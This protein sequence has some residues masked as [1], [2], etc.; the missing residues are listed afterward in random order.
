MKI[1]DSKSEIYTVGIEEESHRIARSFNC[2][3]G[4]FPLTYLGLPISDRRLSKAELSGTATK[5]EKRLQAWK[6][7]HLSHGGR[8]ILINSSLTSIPMYTMGFYWLYEGNHQRVDFGRG[9]FFW[10][11]MGNKKKFHMIK[12][13]AL[14]KPKEFGGLGFIDTRA[15][16]TALLCKWIFRLESGEDSMCMRLLRKK[17]LGNLSFCQSQSAGASQFWQGLHSVKNWYEKGKG[18]IVGCGKQTRFWKHVWLD[19]CPLKVSYSRLFNICH[20]QEI[21]V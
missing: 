21:S 19:E 4:T 11:G 15:M 9:K 17:Y 12:W 3:L 5:I 10:E 18:H 14:D 2:K 13:E 20:D 1:N 7:G 6:C 16:N 8:S